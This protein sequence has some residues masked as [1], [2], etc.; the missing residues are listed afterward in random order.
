MLLDDFEDDVFTLLEAN[1]LRG[2][3]KTHAI[4]KQRE[5]EG[6][7]TILIQNHLMSDDDKFIKYF[8]V[9][10]RVF[11]TI[12]HHIRDE[13]STKASNRVQ[14]PI[15]AEQKLCLALRYFENR[16]NFIAHGFN[17]VFSVFTDI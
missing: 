12:L 1:L 2:R 7:Y 5:R 8:R 15:T 6:A 16:Y 17:V 14:N 10:P 13:I 4:Y 9:T 11:Q 3:R